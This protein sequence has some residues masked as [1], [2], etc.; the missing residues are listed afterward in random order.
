[1][2]D[3]K[4]APQYEVNS[5]DEIVKFVDNYLTCT[6]SNSSDMADLINLQTHRH[7]KTCEKRSAYL[8]V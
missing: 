2:L 7:A 8:Q 5:N 4:N 1:M 3:K 6:N